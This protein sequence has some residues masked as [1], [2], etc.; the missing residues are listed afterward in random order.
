MR[1]SRNKTDERKS[2]EKLRTLTNK[3]CKKI[4][5]QTLIVKISENFQEKFVRCLVNTG[6]LTSQSSYITLF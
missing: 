2:Y 4:L 6:S 5:F 1:K 3:I